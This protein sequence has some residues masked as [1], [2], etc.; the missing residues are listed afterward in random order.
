MK[1]NKPQGCPTLTVAITVKLNEPHGYS[2]LTVTITVKLTEPQGCLTLT[3]IVAV[4]LQV[5][6]PSRKSYHRLNREILAPYRRNCTNT[7]QK[8]LRLSGA[9]TSEIDKSEIDKR[10]NLTEVAKGISFNLSLCH[11]FV[12]LKV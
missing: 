6:P 9:L 3:V 10:G 12:V 4:K 2:T 5:C 1:P 11:D 7:I 8:A